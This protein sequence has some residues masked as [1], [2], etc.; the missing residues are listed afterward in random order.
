M[1]FFLGQC[2]L[3]VSHQ[4]EHVVVLRVILHGGEVHRLIGHY[5]VR[6][7]PAIPKPWLLPIHVT[8]HLHP[9]IGQFLGRFRYTERC[10]LFLLL[11]CWC[12]RVCGSLR[13]SSI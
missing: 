10:F 1:S 11:K 5:A 9:L 4:R 6:L 13:V 12:V 8:L 7:L 2:L 3:S